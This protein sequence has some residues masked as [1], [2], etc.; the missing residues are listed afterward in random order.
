MEDLLRELK[1]S[2]QEK[3]NKV[4]SG[5]LSKLNISNEIAST[6]H[7]AGRMAIERF[8][9][10]SEICAIQAAFLNVNSSLRWA[11]MCMGE[12]GKSSMKLA[13]KAY[14]YFF[15]GKLRFLLIAS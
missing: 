6:I 10:F 11:C 12:Q 7:L 14:V 2:L 5:V 4:Q 13:C 15:V 1:L 8:D 3:N 9:D